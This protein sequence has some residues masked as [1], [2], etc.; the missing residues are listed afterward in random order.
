[1]L[2]GKFPLGP[3]TILISKPELE[4]E[5]GDISTWLGVA[6]AEVLPP[7]RPAS[8]AVEGERDTRW[9]PVLPYRTPAKRLVFAMCWAA[10]IFYT[11]F[12]E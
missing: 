1:M 2:T 10:F 5:P 12:G 3:P 8:P 4:D 9:L 7:P 11:R 6:V